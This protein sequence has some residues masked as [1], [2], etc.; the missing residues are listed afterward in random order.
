MVNRC[1]VDVSEIEIENLAHVAPEEKAMPTSTSLTEQNRA[2][3]LG[4]FEAASRSDVE[5]VFSFLA[6]DVTVIEPQFMPFG[7]V[8]HGKEGF[9]ELA[10]Y[11]PNYFNLP[12][13]TVHYTIADG[14]RV[15]AFVSMADITGEPTRFIEQFTVKDGKIIENRMFYNNAGTLV[16]EPKVV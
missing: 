2:V 5:G 7:K 12:S 14:D 13:I 11:L 9:L 16:G 1:W 6:D 8:Y 4:M 10:Q 15:A 3:V